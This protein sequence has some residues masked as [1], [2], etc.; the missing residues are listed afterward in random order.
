MS[1]KFI[2]Y[3]NNETGHFDG[4]LFFHDY[5]QYMKPNVTPDYFDWFINF[6]G[7]FYIKEL[8]MKFEFKPGYFKVFNYNLNE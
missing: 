4:F 6:F 1:N 7:W 5:P 8:N 3:F 2:K